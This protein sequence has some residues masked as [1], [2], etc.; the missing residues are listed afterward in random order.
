LKP[1]LSRSIGGEANLYGATQRSALGEKRNYRHKMTEGKEVSFSVNSYIIISINE[2]KRRCCETLTE[3]FRRKRR[4]GPGIYNTRRQER[5][6]GK[7]MAESGADGASLEKGRNGAEAARKNLKSGVN[8]LIEEPRGKRRQKVFLHN[9]KRALSRTGRTKGFRGVVFLMYA[10]RRK[11]GWE[12][13]AP[14]RIETSWSV[15]HIGLLHKH[16]KK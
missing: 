2:R 7:E 3:A 9:G 14:G 11:R 16:R 6:A 12:K 5:K 8:C 1:H 10:E 15:G 4:R 13:K